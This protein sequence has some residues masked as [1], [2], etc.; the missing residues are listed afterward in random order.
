V[1]LKVISVE[2]YD[3]EINGDDP[4]FLSI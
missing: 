3:N 1:K 4:L 2:F